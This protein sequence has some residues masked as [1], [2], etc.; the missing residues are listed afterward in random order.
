MSYRVRIPLST[1]CYLFYLT[2]TGAC[3]ISPFSL[4][5]LN[6]TTLCFHSLHG[7]CLL[8][9]SFTPRAEIWINI[10]CVNYEPVPWWASDRKP[11][12]RS[13]FDSEFQLRRSNEKR[14]HGDY[15][16]RPHSSFSQLPN[17]CSQLCLT[18]TPTPRLH[19]IF[20]TAFNKL[21]NALVLFSKRTTSLICRFIT[22]TLHSVEFT[23]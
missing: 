7:W 3:K 15:E 9:P 5:S 20:T 4:S 19:H 2:L 10:C 18:N 21:V 1:K 11:F 22:Y 12:F 23:R 8:K 17:T 6:S 16:G 14:L 13:H